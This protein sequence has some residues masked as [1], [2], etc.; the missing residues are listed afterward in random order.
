[1]KQVKIVATPPGEAPKR[2]RDAWI[3]VVLPI[4]GDRP[5]K[6]LG[7]GVKSG[8]TIWFVIKVFLGW[9]KP[10]QGYS[11]DAAKA[12]DILSQTAPDA[13]QWWRKN[14]SNALEPGMLLIFNQEVCQEVD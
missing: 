11:V 3:G 12:V 5:N 10:I 8:L 2:I 4:K 1:M 9:V 13:A 6:R 7:Y 14:A